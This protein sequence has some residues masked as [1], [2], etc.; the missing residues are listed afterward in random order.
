MYTFSIKKI[1]QLKNIEKPKV[2][3]DAFFISPNPSCLP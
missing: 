2:P 3:L 1:S